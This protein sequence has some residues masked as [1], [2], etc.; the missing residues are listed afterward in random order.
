[1]AAVAEAELRRIFRL[2]R[3]EGIPRLSGH[4]S[5]TELP[6][7]RRRF[8]QQFV[9]DLAVFA[10][11]RGF[12]WPDVSR[13]A[14]MAKGLFPHLE[15]LDAASLPFLLNDA[16]S[17]CLPHLTPVHRH[18][19]TRHLTD[20]L[21]SSG[22]LLQAVV[23]GAAAPSITRAHLEV[24]TPPRPLPLAQVLKSERRGGDTSPLAVGLVTR[25]TSCTWP[26]EGTDVKEVEQQQQ[27]AKLTAALKQKEEELKR[28]REGSEVILAEIDTAEDRRLDK[29]GVLELVRASVRASGGRMLASLDREI[30][31][32]EDLLELK[33]QHAA[34][35]T[36][37]LQRPTSPRGASVR[38]ARSKTGSRKAKASHKA[39]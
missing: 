13:V 18:E 27:Q 8:H 15:G 31:L 33:L 7:E 10:A 30:S 16:L 23:A 17:G 3:E 5:W 19:L 38:R 37:G 1:M 11:E 20:T 12:P 39:Q 22:R 4:F 29:E 2:R 35:T 32:T 21:A 25:N 14:V 36:R 26:L 34:V 24:A 6:G 9:F 28:L